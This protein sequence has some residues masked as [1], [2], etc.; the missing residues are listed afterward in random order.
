MA[1]QRDVTDT[2]ILNN[3]H[4]IKNLSEHYLEAVVVGNSIPSA[5]ELYPSTV[6]IYNTRL[7][8]KSEN[9]LQKFSP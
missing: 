2:G 4:F 8:K 5:P 9:L 3:T 1:Y 7:E 6:K